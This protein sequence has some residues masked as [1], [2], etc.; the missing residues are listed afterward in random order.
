LCHRDRTG[1]IRKV[2]PSGAPRLLLHV[3]LFALAMTTP[4][5]AGGA[6]EVPPGKEVL[7]I[8]RI[9]GKMGA[10]RFGHADHVKRFSRPDGSAIRC[11]DC[12]HTLEADDPPVPLPAMRCSGCHPEVGQPPRQIDGKSALPMA[13][14][15]PDGAVDYRTIL[16]HEYCR[17]CHL[18]VK[19][20]G[21]R[22]LAVCKACH[23][24]GI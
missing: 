2:I 23:E 5:L 6:A 14:R 9:P 24:H 8:D 4:V 3:G 7:L 21:G 10:V 22:R 18:K 20:E 15:K 16:F 13:F 19:R 12:H 11:R 1:T 17:A